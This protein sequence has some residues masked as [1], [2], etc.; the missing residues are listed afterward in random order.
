MTPRLK[1]FILATLSLIVLGAVGF[2]AFIGSPAGVIVGGIG[3]AVFGP[4][5]MLMFGLPAHLLLNWFGKPSLR[6]Y[7]WAGFIVSAA[8]A[9]LAAI[10][11]PH[12]DARLIF[13]FFQI[14]LIIIGG[15]LAASVFWWGA[16]P[17]LATQQT[18]TPPA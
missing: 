8:L 10:P 11:V 3:S 17:D 15:P 12:G 2:A 18:Q 5:A 6:A 14:L 16:R 13:Q 1:G 4:M 9:A 7:V